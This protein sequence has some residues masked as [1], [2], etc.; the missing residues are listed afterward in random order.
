VNLRLGVSLGKSRPLYHDFTLPDPSRP[1]AEPGRR[2][3]P[4]ARRNLQPA[5]GAVG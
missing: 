4:Q 2:V 1:T 5:R 3:W